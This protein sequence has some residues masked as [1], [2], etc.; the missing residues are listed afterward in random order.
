MNPTSG[1]T[2]TGTPTELVPPGIGLKYSASI[3]GLRLSKSL[4]DDSETGASVV[5]IDPGVVDEVDAESVVTTSGGTATA[6]VSVLV[7][8]TV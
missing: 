2:N 4:A 1:D 3:C 5:D 6:L 8:G 7:G